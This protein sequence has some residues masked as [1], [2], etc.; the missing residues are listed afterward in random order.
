MTAPL[1]LL[2]ALAQVGPVLPTPSPARPPEAAQTDAP[3][4]REPG[5]A[6]QPAARRPAPDALGAMRRDPDYRYDRPVAE[7]PTLGER[8]TRWFFENVLAPFFRFSGSRG[9]QGFWFVVAALV[10]LAVAL[11]VTQTGIGGLFGRRQKTIADGA[12]PLLGVTDI[13]AVDLPALLDAAVARG[14]WR[15][16]V[17]LRY[18][19][20]LQRLDAAGVV[21]W[22]ADTTNRAFVRQATARGGADVGRAFADVTRAFDTVWYGGLSV[23]AARWARVDARYDRLD[24]ALADAPRPVRT[25]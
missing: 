2:L 23:D 21:A 7:G 4:R 19:V 16:A 17:R 1:A 22:S 6:P 3:V 20:A 24:A 9:G 5:R 10:L 14:A 8:V 25:A 11:R 18:L 13:A 12:D 15:E